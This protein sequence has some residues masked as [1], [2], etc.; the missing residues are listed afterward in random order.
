MY[1]FAGKE[2]HTDTGLARSSCDFMNLPGGEIGVFHEVDYVHLANL[3][4]SGLI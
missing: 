2:W 3:P 1:E 4:A